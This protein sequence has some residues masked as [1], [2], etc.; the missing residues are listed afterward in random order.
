[1]REFIKTTLIGGAVFLIPLVLVLFVLGYA[2][3][4]AR[5][6]LHPLLPLLELVQIGPFGGVGLLTVLAVVVVLLVSFAAGVF[7]RTR[8]GM[9][10]TG[11]V[12]NSAL[13]RLPQYRMIRT[14]MGTL[15]PGEP[16]DDTR[17]AL[18]A[19]EAG[20]QLCY[21]VETLEN[22]WLAVF[23]PAAPSP[24]TGSVMYYPPDRV[25]QLKI[26]VVQA[27]GILRSLGAGSAALLSGADAA[28]LSSPL[29]QG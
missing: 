26:S 5:D 4:L 11:Y 17:A 21:V 3:S 27:A 1:M 10:L 9:R 8:S 2:I 19:V 29:P 28:A 23:V 25:R 24:M 22:G 6:A 7:A 15:S 13:G 14:M 12:E 16:S 20:W 18:L